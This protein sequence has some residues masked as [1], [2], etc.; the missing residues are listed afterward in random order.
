MDYEITNVLITGGCGFI[1]SN[2]LNHLV[3]KY[4][5]VTFVN[6][7]CLYYC[8]TAL[9]NDSDLSRHPTQHYGIGTEKLRLLQRIYFG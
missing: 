3:E 4:P 1:A 6:L 5:H 8:G 7:D 2:V 9:K